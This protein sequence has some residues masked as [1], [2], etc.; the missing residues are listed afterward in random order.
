MSQLRMILLF[1]L[2]EILYL[3]LVQTVKHFPITEMQGA[4]FEKNNIFSKLIC[5]YDLC[6]AFLVG[7]NNELSVMKID[8]Q[9]NG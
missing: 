3:D 8:L 5:K 6:K 2:G 4:V 7:R 1:V 9:I